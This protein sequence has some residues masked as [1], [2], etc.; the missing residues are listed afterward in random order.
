MEEEQIE[1]WA[2]YEFGEAD[3]GDKRRRE[4]L[5]E[6]AEALGAKPEASLPQALAGQAALKAAYRFFDNPA[7]ESQSILDGHIQAT[8]RR[9]AEV[10][11]VL[12]VQDTTYL[13]WTHH[14]HTQGL[15]P[16]ASEE[17]QG[18]LVHST[19]VMTPER[20][21]LGVLQQQVWA[22]DADTYAQL[23][24]HKQRQ[25]DEKESRKW[26]IS[27]ESVVAARVAN[28]DTCF[29]S[30]GDREADI[31][32]L[33]LAERGVGVDLLVRATQDRRIENEEHYLWAAMIAT[34]LAA[35]IQ[36]NVPRQPG[37]PQ[38]IATVEVRWQQVILR[39]PSKR[40]SENLP[41]MAVWVVWA[42]ETTAPEGVAKIEWM[43]LNTLQVCSTAEALERLNWYACRWGIEVWHK[44]LK[45]GC[46]IESRQ[47]ESAERLKRLLTLF[48]VVAWR[49]LYAAM[50]ARALPEAPCTIFFEDGEWQALYCTAHNT[51]IVPQQPPTLQEAIRLVARLGGFIGRKQ[52]GQPGVTVL[53]KGFQRLPDL[54]LMYK[55][56]R[57]SEGAQQ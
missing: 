11:L 44:I 53:W 47:L 1:N 50:L 36:V 21:P 45:S 3:L 29:V 42:V 37:R 2:A 51:P 54:T 4:R 10:P 8:Y 7:V 41:S 13:D 15:G 57:P 14:P 46:Q 27:L 26:L 22:R 34:P 39:P 55:L 56:L 18:L 19:L 40:K 33:F 43:L 17:R 12:A 35:T 9:M 31:Y 49:I 5:I 23:K 25:I 48:S 24:D 16:L 52:D 28:P 32:D 30:V 6:L 38:R 20:V